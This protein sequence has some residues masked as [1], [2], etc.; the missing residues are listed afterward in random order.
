MS[1]TVA[2]APPAPLGEADR[3]AAAVVACPG[4]ARLVGGGPAPLATYLPGRRVDGV[5]VGAE[6]VQVAVVTRYPVPVPQV[7]AQIRTA[8]AG[9]AAGR[10]VDVHVA[11]IDVPDGGSGA[12]TLLDR[13]LP[14]GR[15]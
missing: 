10:P 7:A 14:P 15:Q 11:D 3:I 4:V 13:S 8:V 9:L 12:D 2:A 1:E 5:R 6:R